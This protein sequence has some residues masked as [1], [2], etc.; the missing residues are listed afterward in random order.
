MNILDARYLFLL[1]ATFGARQAYDTSMRL[2]F[3][4]LQS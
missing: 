1:D 3:P 2:I 4:A